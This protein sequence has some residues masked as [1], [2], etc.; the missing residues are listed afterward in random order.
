MLTVMGMLT[1][2]LA[3][4]GGGSLMDVNPGLI[5]WTVVTFLVLLFILS[6][7]AWKPIVAALNQREDAIKESLEKA[8]KAQEEAKK[9][10]EQNQANLAKAEE[11]SRKIIDQSRA[12][13]EKLKQQL[14]QESKEQANKIV[15]DATAE[16][17]RQK[18]AAF[19][20][21]KNQVAEI[22]INAAEKILRESLDKEAQKKLVNKY[23]SEIPKN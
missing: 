13:A 3:P 14:L 18:E 5:F 21:L 15:Q 8:E 7:V 16:I 17:D 12:Y 20:E 4:E 23:I 11:E 2:A 19:S 1:L 9:I 6:K 10:L 22:A